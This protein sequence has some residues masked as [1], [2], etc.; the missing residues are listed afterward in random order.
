MDYNFNYDFACKYGVNEA[1]FCN[2]LY[3]WIRKNRANRKH[4]YDGHYWSYNTLSSFAELFEFWTEKQIR[5]VISNCEKKGL[6]MKGNYNKTAYDRTV[7]YALTPLALEMYETPKPLDNTEMPKRENASESTCPNG[8]INSTKG[9]NQSDQ[10]GEPIPD[11]K[12]DNKQQIKN[13]VNK[14]EVNKRNL[15]DICNTFFET[16]AS[17]RWSKDQ[18][19]IIIDSFVNE[20]LE[21]GRMS[22]VDNVE[23]YIRNSL[24][25]IAYHYDFRNGR[26][27]IKNHNS[28]VPF[29]NWLES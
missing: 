10:K 29:Y 18:W 13:L 20:L 6:I 4:F 9:A 25:N 22:F 15:T 17:G 8:Q 27:E 2:N 1:I 11:N 5:T 12:P 21:D 7:W 24:K 26:I 14:R 23:G 28:K 19:N 16:F 3:F